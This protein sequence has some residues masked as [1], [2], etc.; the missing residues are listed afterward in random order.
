MR[1]LVMAGAA[2]AVP[3]WGLLCACAVGIFDKENEQ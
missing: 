3:A 1:A 2:V